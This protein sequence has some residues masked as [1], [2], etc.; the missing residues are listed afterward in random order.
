MF[1]VL[2]EREI[3]AER[4]SQSRLANHDVVVSALNDRLQLTAFRG[5]DVEFIH[6]LLNWFCATQA[7]DDRIVRLFYSPLFRF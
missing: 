7:S 1:Q 5:G 4:P 3:C 2:S 6:R